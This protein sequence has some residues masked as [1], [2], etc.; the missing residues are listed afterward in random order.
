[1]V[2]LKNVYYLM[3]QYAITDTKLY[4]SVITLS[5]QYN[6]KLLQQLKSGF[7]GAI[8]WN[9]NQPKVSTKKKLVLRLINQSKS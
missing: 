8:N 7:K 6:A 2:D 5:P 9:Y 3:I 4:I 1:M